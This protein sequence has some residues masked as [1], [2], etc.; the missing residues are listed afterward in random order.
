MRK[1]Y[2]RLPGPAPVR[3]L[4][5]IVI[6]IVVFIALIPLFEWAGDYLDDGGVIGAL[7]ATLR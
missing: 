2:D 4:I 7:S 1:L 3:V 6:A 5:M